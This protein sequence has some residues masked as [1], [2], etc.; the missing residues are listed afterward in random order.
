MEIALNN[1]EAAL[2]NRHDYS[3]KLIKNLRDVNFLLGVNINP[4]LVSETQC[5]V[6]Y[7]KQ[8]S[9]KFDEFDTSSPSNE[10][11]IDYIKN[12]K[13]D[14]FAFL[15]QHFLRVWGI[16]EN[17]DKNVYR[18]HQLYY[19]REMHPFLDVSEFNRR[20]YD[21][22]LG[23]A[24][25][26]VM[27]NMFYNDEYVGDTSFAKLIHRY[28]CSIPMSRANINRKNFL[29]EK[30]RK[31]LSGKFDVRIASIACGP[32]RELIDILAE[33]II[34]P[35]AVFTCFDS[36]K[37]AIDDVKSRVAN[38]QRMKNLEFNVRFLNENILAALKKQDAHDK[39]GMQ[40]FIYCAGLIDYFNDKLARR[41]ISVLFSLLKD[42]GVLIIGNVSKGNP[43]RAY[44]E[45]LGEW[46]VIDR[47]GDDMLRLAE[48]IKTYNAKTIQFEP[49]TKRNV[50]LV[51]NK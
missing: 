4:L 42:R 1:Y 20:I 33:D 11:Q 13:T 46:I 36:E 51:I 28:T 39:I 18:N 12:N 10:Q 15:D 50:F 27:M 29:K 25:D 37:L 48:D 31:A 23:Y 22:P 2:L 3:K 30:I 38:I 5:A 16:F 24:G 40:D 6:A 44:T 45:I 8:I 14:I 9:D 26:F 34:S 43:S 47:D 21:K 49:E 17:L 19:Q 7:L 35:E 41:F 32:A